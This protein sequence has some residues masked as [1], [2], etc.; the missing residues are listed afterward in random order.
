MEETRRAKADQIEGGARTVT[1]GARVDQME[2]GAREK[3]G[4]TWSRRSQVGPRPQPRWRFMVE[5]TEGGAMV[6]EGLTTLGC[7]PTATEEVVVVEPEVEM[8]S[9][10]DR[11][12]LRIRKAKAKL[13]ALA[14][15]A[16]ARIWKVA[17]ELEQLRTK[18]DSEGRI[19]LTEPEVQQEKW[20]PVAA[21]GQRLTKVEP[22]R[23]GGP[24]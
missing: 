2:R 8:D 21:N 10:R 7:R 6:E 12:T 17:V 24:W 18:V 23:R 1:E 4:G 9:Q 22:E 14:T 13:M 3:T 20:S 15:E 16:K 11:V 19:G 5:L